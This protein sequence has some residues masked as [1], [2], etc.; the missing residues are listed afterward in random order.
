MDIGHDLAHA[1]RFAQPD[2]LSLD[3]IPRLQSHTI[4]HEPLLAH[5][6]SDLGLGV[7]LHCLR[8]GIAEVA[9]AAAFALF[10]VREL[11][12]HAIQCVIA[13]DADTALEGVGAR[14]GVSVC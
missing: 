8:R 14:H 9:H 4:V 1:S 12:L 7:M 13:C 11:V 10:G 3:G 2:Y 6:A 5:G